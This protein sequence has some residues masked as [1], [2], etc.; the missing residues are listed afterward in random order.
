[1]VPVV[2]L[3]QNFQFSQI[4]PKPFGSGNFYKRCNGN[5]FIRI[6]P[7]KQANNSKQPPTTSSACQ[8]F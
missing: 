5:D 8:H 4:R 2:G 1:M 7:S 3:D 6:D